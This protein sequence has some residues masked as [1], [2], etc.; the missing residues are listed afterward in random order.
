LTRRA[1]PWRDGMDT[2][3]STGKASRSGEFSRGRRYQGEGRGQDAEGAV[4]RQATCIINGV[5]REEEP[6]LGRHQ[7]CPE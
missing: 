2:K 6:K 4:Q 1:R 5:C 3:I 7:R